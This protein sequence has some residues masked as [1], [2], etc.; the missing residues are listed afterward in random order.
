[1][2]LGWIL[3]HERFDVVNAYGFKSTAI[4]RLLVRF[5]ARDCAFVSGVR[6]LHVTEL[7]NLS[8]PKSR[9]ALRLERLGAG[10]VDIYDANSEGALDLL[11]ATGIPRERMRYIPNGIDLS[12]WSARTARDGGGP[13]MVLCVAR[14]VP[15]KR[16]Q[17][18][19]E[20]TA[21]LADRGMAFRLVLVGDG[22]TLP[23]MKARADGL[24]MEDR[25]DFAGAL[26]ANEVQALVQQA[27]I[28]CLPSAWEGMA[29]SVMEAMA[30]A[31]PVVG[32]DVNGVAELVE[33]GQTG[34][35]VPPGEPACLAMALEEL[36]RSPETRR[37]F[38]RAGRERIAEHFSLE[39]MVSAKE[40]LYVTLAQDA[41]R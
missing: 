5:L 28:F 26:P 4:V 14:F 18:L 7:E 27:D 35:L 2:R 31:V 9:L 33:H 19:L 12:G 3:R 32:T 22:P 8:S 21:R 29:G 23:D 24:G 34:L 15:R 6:G 20:A 38:G 11:A 17:D 30:S 1:V 10:F 41:R 13:P 39:G 37:R 40:D 25:V 36:L 16:H